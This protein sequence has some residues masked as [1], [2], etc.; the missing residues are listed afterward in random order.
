M[1]SK[2]QLLLEKAYQDVLN[3]AVHYDTTVGEIDVGK[4]FLAKGTGTSKK[5][6]DNTLLGLSGKEYSIKNHIDRP[7]MIDPDIN[8][9]DF[10]L[11]VDFRTRKISKEEF[12]SKVQ[13]KKLE[14]D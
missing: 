14:R 3:E 7:C 4:I 1:K 8:N 9:H 5:I 6:S 2:D 11:F 12:N 10:E 13:N